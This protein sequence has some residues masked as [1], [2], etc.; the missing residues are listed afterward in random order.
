MLQPNP[1]SVINNIRFSVVATIALGSF[2]VSAALVNAAG[3]N[4]AARNAG[5]KFRT[6]YD[7]LNKV[8]AKLSLAE[9]KNITSWRRKG[10]LWRS[11]AKMMMTI[12]TTTTIVRRVITRS[13]LP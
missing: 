2:A 13:S 4:L 11:M 9:K 1:T 12:T 8:Y 3:K 7:I 5:L 6:D 10:D